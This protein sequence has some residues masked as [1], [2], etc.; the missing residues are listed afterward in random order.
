METVCCLPSI[1]NLNTLGFIFTILYRP[2]YGQLAGELNQGIETAETLEHS[3]WETNWKRIIQAATTLFR[4][5]IL[6]RRPPYRLSNL[7]VFQVIPQKEHLT[8]CQV[9]VPSEHS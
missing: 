8:S 2:A 4:K 9:D 7:S 1:F 5:P 3:H 6:Q